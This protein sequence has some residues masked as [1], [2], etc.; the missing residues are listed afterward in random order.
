[1][2]DDLK[3]DLTVVLGKAHM[4]IH[5]LLRMG[6][7][8][9]LPLEGGGEDLVEVLANGHPIARAEILVTG[10]SVAIEIRHMIHKPELVRSPGLRIGASALSPRYEMGTDPRD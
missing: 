2:L 6:R 7:G 9:V 3:V 10:N 4:P 8:A 1:M 5:Q